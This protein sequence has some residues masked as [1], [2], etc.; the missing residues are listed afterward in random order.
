[1]KNGLKL[2]EYCGGNIIADSPMD[3][4]ITN[5]HVPGNARNSCPAQIN[6]EQW[7][8]LL[9]TLEDCAQKPKKH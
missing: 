1:M 3:T 2:S 4:E 8:K 6:S 7:K 5:T 9:S